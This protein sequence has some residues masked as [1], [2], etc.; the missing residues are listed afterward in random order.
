MMLASMCFMTGCA[1]LVNGPRSKE[2]ADRAAMDGLQSDVARLRQQVGEL[3][4]GRQAEFMS[5][6]T[7]RAEMEREKR[8]LR[9]KLAEIENLV[10]E[11]RSANVAMKQE[12]ID[13]LSK[14]M[15][16]ILKGSGQRSSSG[17]GRR[18]SSDGRNHVV[19]PGETLSQIAST[20]NTTPDAIARANDLQNPDVLHAGQKLVIP[21]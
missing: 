8:E 15:A 17:G 2:A 12:I 16:E 10:S 19:A 9:D 20:Y 13:H 1:S 18:G 4:A 21:E 11:L 3:E 14:R 6:E 7:A 5:L